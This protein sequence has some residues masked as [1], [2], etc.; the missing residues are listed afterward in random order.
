M[1]VNWFGR[2]PHRQPRVHPLR[3]R[4][5]LQGLEDRTVPST[6]MALTTSNRLLTFDSATPGHI[7]SARP[8]TG[9]ASGES[10]LGI[11]VRPATGELYGL[12]T[13]RL[14]VIDPNTG[15]ATLKAVLAPD[16]ADT[17]D[18]FKSLTGTSFGI[19]F[20]PAADRL[21]VVSDAD[22]NLR[23]NPDTGQVFTDAPLAYAPGD[24]NAGANPSV[25]EA[26]YTSN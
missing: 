18:P 9:L 14:Y 23:I 22:Q 15:A 21:R 24:V 17:N 1:P 12:G 10:L 2:W 8:I 6:V 19:D 11:D 3:T 13:N 26:A 16:P 4:P 5:A 7:L 20:N 25:V